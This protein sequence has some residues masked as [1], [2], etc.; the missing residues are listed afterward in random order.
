M[1]TSVLETPFVEQ[2]ACGKTAQ[3]IYDLLITTGVTKVR[4]IEFT[5]SQNE[6]TVSILDENKNEEAK[7]FVYRSR[8]NIEITQS[9]LY[10]NIIAEIQLLAQEFVNNVAVT[11]GDGYESNDD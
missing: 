11:T 9:C 10:S 8:V 6:I 4:S 5:I 3:F 1:E 2:S 7:F